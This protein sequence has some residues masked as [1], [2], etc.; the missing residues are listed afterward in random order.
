MLITLLVIAAVWVLV[1]LL[2]V[3]LMFVAALVLVGTLNPIVG[4]LE[5]KRIRRKAR[6]RSCLGR[7]VI[8]IALLLFLTI[9]PLVVQLRGLVER[10]PEMRGRRL[11][12]ANAR[13]SRTR[14]RS[15]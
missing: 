8:L 7:P 11:S 13:R 10:E 3:V 2:P 14:W 4:W 6:S 5:T 12:Y 1:K 15:S 9:P